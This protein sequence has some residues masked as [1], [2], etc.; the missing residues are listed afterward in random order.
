[1]AAKEVLDRAISGQQTEID[2]DILA[3]FTLV[4]PIHSRQI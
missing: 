2:Q 3:D 4:R 1:M